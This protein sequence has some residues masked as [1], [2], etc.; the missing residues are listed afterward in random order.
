M[1]SGALEKP[2]ETG[3]QSEKMKGLQTT[4]MS[5]SCRSF[6]GSVLETCHWADGVPFNLCLYQM[7]LEACFDADEKTSIVEEVDEVLD[8]VK[9]TLGWS[10]GI[11]QMLHNL[12]FSWVLVVCRLRL[13]CS[14]LLI[15]C[16]LK[17]KR[18]QK[19]LRIRLEFNIESDSGL[20][21]EKSSFLTMIPFTVITLM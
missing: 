16:R 17:L 11:N 6:D 9:K 5:L 19:Q 7:F 14:L 8:L 12:C 13:T 4:V 1:I 3:K 15:V 10:F 18:M 21:R 20:D 2:I